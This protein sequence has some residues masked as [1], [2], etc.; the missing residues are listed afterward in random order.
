VYQ[1]VIGWCADIVQH[2]ARKSSTS[3]VLRGFQGTGKT[4]FGKVIGSLLGPQYLPI[5]DSRY[6]VGQFNSHLISCPLL[7][8][9][10]SFWAGDHAAEGKLKHLVTGDWHM[11]ELKGIEPIKV[12]NYVRLLVTGNQDWIVPA[13]KEE[14]R[15]AVLDVGDK[16]REDHK[17]FA[18][19]ERQMEAGGRE[20]LLHHLLNFDLS[21]VNLRTIPKTGPQYRPFRLLNR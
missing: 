9:D 18:A 6:I 7:H 20:A 13:A 11:I 1:W 19:I 5:A 2:P 3:L 8:A 17:Y 4:I 15:F 14:R 10:E 12:R 21:Q 16:H